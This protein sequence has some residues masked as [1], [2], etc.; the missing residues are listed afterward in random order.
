MVAFAVILAGAIL[1]VSARAAAQSR[2][3]AARPDVL[4]VGGTPAGVAAAIAAARRHQRVTLVAAGRDLGGIL[5]DGFMNQWDLNVTDD[6]AS[7]E[8]GIFADMYDRL[9]N[10]F[11]PDA[12]AQTFADMVA[13]E[14]NIIVRYGMAAIGVA[15]SN[16][17]DGR[18]VDAVMFKSA[19]SNMTTIVRAPEIVDA[20]DSADI[21]AMAGARY[22]RGRQDTGV[23]QR[24]QAVTEMFTLDGVDWD[25]VQRG[26]DAAQFGPGRALPKT[27]WGYAKLMH[28]YKPVQ[29]NAIVRD[30]NLAH[31][32]DGSVTVNA[33]DIVGIDG[34]DP[35][36]VEQA[37]R[38]TTVEAPHLVD[39][40]RAHLPG[41]ENARIGKYAPDVYVRETRHIDGVE[42]LTS[43]DVWDGKIPDDSI[44]LASYPMDVHPVDIGDTPAFASTRHVYGIPFGAL[45]PKGLDN[46]ILAGPA[47]SAS[48]EASGSARIVA[49]TIEEGEAAGA[50]A[51]YAN[52][53]HLDFTQI[54]SNHERIDVLRRDLADNGAT[55]GGPLVEVGAPSA[56]RKK[57]ERRTRADAVTGAS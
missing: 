30:Q 55:V 24:M 17:P 9:G 13:R 47:I 7:V 52:A 36:Q 26:Y 6:G 43:K 31:M 5:V 10:A 40:L 33:I 19:G 51:A 48:H 35:Q 44:A 27:A 12:A 21:A 41:F 11:E 45:V 23:D 14:P 50:A 29:P 1:S 42:R 3:D 15:P 57:S 34:L 18:H 56:V 25:T 32:P 39:F 28:D 38:N 8:R 16:W 37:K 2:F 49:T 22:D 20:T 54:A 46:V 4:V 53:H